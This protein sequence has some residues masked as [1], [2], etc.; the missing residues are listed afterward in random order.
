[1]LEP[2]FK[3]SELPMDLCLPLAHVGTQIPGFP[4]AFLSWM[5]GSGWPK[6]CQ[7]SVS[8]MEIHWPNF[9]KVTSGFGCFNF[10]V[11]KLRDHQG[12]IVFREWVLSNFCKS[13]PIK[14][15]HIGYPKTE[16]PKTISP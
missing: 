10:W 16:V 1:M 4:L 7:F 8:F 3:E 6:L 5:G 12:D 2:P 15:S 14:V 11:P 13:V 9:S